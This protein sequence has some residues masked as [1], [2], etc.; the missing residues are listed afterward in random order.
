MDDVDGAGDSL[1]R[2]IDG[3]GGGP[4]VE[5]FDIGE[6]KTSSSASGTFL[7]FPGRLLLTVTGSS[8]RTT[9]LVECMTKS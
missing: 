1:V 4:I 9:K 2:G 3:E 8:E 6:A 7:A 5:G